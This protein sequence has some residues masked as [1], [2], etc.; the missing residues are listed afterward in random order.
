MCFSLSFIISSAKSQ[1]CIIIA[2]RV[3]RYKKTNIVSGQFQQKMNCLKGYW[4]AHRITGEPEEPDRE[5][6]QK[7][8]RWHRQNPGQSLSAGPHSLEAATAA[9]PLNAECR[10]SRPCQEWAS[11][12]L[13]HV[14]AF[15]AALGKNSPPPPASWHHQCG[16]TLEP[17]LL[18][19][20][21]N[22][23]SWRGGQVL[24]TVTAPKMGSF[25]TA[26]IRAFRSW[27]SNQL[28]MS[29]LGSL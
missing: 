22:R 27:A 19:S 28:H 2:V 9:V 23:A 29:V 7:Q 1:G 13:L 25:P 16:R 6:W 15:A 5:N 8:G 4:L 14:A 10:S 18:G 26:G 20:L 24:L 12:M 11:A 3:L 21:G 17:W